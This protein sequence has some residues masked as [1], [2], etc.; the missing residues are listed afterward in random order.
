MLRP[1]VRRT[2]ALVLAL[3][4]SAALLA[5]APGAAAA[6]AVTAAAPPFPAVSFTYTHHKDWA[7]AVF[8]QLNAERAR[9][10]LP[11]LRW[12]EN[13]YYAAHRHTLLMG[14]NNTLSH[15]LPGEES[16]GTRVTYWYRWSAVGENVAWSSRRTQDG[17]LALETAMY[18]ETPPNDG[19]RRNILSTSYTDVGVDVVDDSTHGRVW[20]TTDFG[21]PR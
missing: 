8:A 18:D 2:A 12:N 3:G 20:L 10:G 6:P 13:L 1:L 14:Q 16:L 5:P 7:K 21:R 19:H 15:Q 4:A 11:A 9:N 17:A